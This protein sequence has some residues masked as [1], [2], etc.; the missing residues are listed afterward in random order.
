MVLGDSSTN[1]ASSQRP[2][3]EE[4]ARV[5]WVASPRPYH[6]VGGRTVSELHS[7]CVFTLCLGTGRDDP[8]KVQLTPCLMLSSP[9]HLVLDGLYR[10]RGSS[11]QLAKEV[12]CFPRRV[13]CLATLPVGQRQGLHKSLRKHNSV[14]L[15][16]LILPAEF[17]WSFLPYR[18]EN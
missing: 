14:L 10:A 8:T 11:C 15:G 2:H 18:Q 16:R 6:S 1:C 17:L 7:S 9:S 12:G 13:T 3:L 4:E 5:P